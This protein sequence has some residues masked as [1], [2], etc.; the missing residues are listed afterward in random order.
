MKVCLVNKNTVT[1]DKRTLQ[2]ATILTHSGLEVVI[3]GI[4][5]AGYSLSE[6]NNGFYIKRMKPPLGIA[7][8]FRNHSYLPI[9]RRLPR[10][11]HK[12]ARIS[13][14]ILLFPLVL[15]DSHLRT[16][17]T[18]SR[19]FKAMLNEKA[20]YYHAH[21]P[22][23][24]LAVTFLAAKIRGAEYVSDFNDIL[25]IDGL[26]SFRKYY[27]QENVWGQELK[28][29][30]EKRIQ[31]TIRLIPEDASSILDIGC[32]DGRI[33]NQLANTCSQVIGLDMS[34]VALRHLAANLSSTSTII[35]AALVVRTCIS[36][37]F[38]NIS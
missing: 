23:T 16:I 9:Q 37:L 32:G 36:C 11:L 33:T 18:Y 7:P 30:E 22:F 35:F 38:P 29:S 31:A 15:L 28:E 27:E 12:W 2:E 14:G 3:I 6:A 5:G 24:L 25:V 26:S 1:K 4:L 13:C 34:Q 21:F 17:I 19:L 20:D 10:Q 8:I